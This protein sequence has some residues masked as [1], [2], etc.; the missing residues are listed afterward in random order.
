MQPK[1]RLF[2]ILIFFQT[3]IASAQVGIGT[4]SPNASTVLDVSSTGKGLLVPRLTNAQ[5]LGISSPAAGLV[6]YNTSSSSHYMYNGTTWNS[7]EDRISG[8]VD[9]GVAIQLDNLKIMLS[10]NN[11]ERSLRIATVSG[12]VNL[13]GSSNNLYPTAAVS[14]GGVISSLD[15]YIRQTNAF[16]TSYTTW[17]PGRTFSWHGS[18][19]KIDIMDETNNHAYRCLLIVGNAFKNNFLSLERIY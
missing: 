13:S 17:E 8:Y 2:V 10:T 16:G 12:T 4:T 9:D 7:L 18:V 19:Q 6:V 1:M 15:G 5:M 11:S 14:S 3:F